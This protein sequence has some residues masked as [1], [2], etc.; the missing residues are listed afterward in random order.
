[1]CADQDTQDIEH[2]YFIKRLRRQEMGSRDKRED[3]SHRGRYFLIPKSATPLFPFHSKTQLNDLALI[4]LSPIYLNADGTARPRCYYAYIYHNSKHVE[5]Q[6]NGR[7]EHRIYIS[8]KLD[9]GEAFQDDIIVMRRKLPCEI[10]DVEN[11]SEDAGDEEPENAEEA[12]FDESSTLKAGFDYYIDWIRKDERAGEW[13][14]YDQ[15]IKRANNNADNATSAQVTAWIDLFENRTRN[16][17]L[18]PVQVDDLIVSKYVEEGTDEE[19]TEEKPTDEPPTTPATSTAQ[20]ADNLEDQALAKFAPLFNSISFRDFVLQ[21]YNNTCAITGTVI[22]YG[23]LN[24]LEAAH[25]TPKCHG[26]FFLPNNGIA[27]RR[28]IHWAF[29]KG[30]FYIDP[31]TLTVHVHEAVKN[32]YL[33]DYDG[34]KIEPTV[35]NFA[36][37]PKYLDYHKQKIYSSFL[38]TGSL[39]KLK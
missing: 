27:M 6:S 8:L 32:S 19:G 21:T 18:D 1:M 33:G 11:E 7:D 31:N 24:N 15:I 12:S 38:H 23:S 25:I 28:D 17:S 37:L 14:I 22:A 36:P 3:Q 2:T 10:A 30:M 26:G 29:D 9:D 35:P 34:K 4:C 5:H 13:G 16:A 39:I 20:P